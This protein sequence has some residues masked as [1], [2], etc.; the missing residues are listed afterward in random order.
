MTSKELRSKWL[1]FYEEKGHLNIGAV[2]LIG[3]G[4]TGVMFN[5]AGMQPLMP[6]LLGQPHPSGK[7]R[8][9]NVQGCVRTVDIESVG[10]AT[11]F[12]FFEM[13]GN[14]SLGDYFKKEKTAWTFELLTEVFGFDKDKICSTVFEGDEKVPRDEETADL[15]KSLGVRPENIFYLPKKDNWW[16][17]EGTVGTPCGPDNEWFYP[18][19][20]GKDS[21]DFLTSNRYVEIGNDVYMQYK[22]TET[23]YEELSGK[24]VDTGFG[25]DRLLLFLNG[26][27]DGYKTDLFAGAVSYLEKVSGRSYDSDEDARKAIRIIADHTRTA[28]MLIGDVNGILPSNTG[29]GYI[30]RRLLRRAIRYCRTLGVDTSA[31]LSVAKV[32]IEEVYGEAYPL[33]VE[34]EQYIL[35]AIENESQRFAATLAGGMRE[36]DKCIAGIQERNEALAAKDPGFRPETV[37]SGEQAF[38]LYDTFGFP[39]ELTEELAAEKGLTVDTE[40]YREC[41]KKQRETA[42]EAFRRNSIETDDSARVLESIDGGKNFTGY[43]GVSGESEIIAIV[44]GGELCG[45]VSEGED[46]IVVLES[47]PFYAESGGQVGDTGVISCGDSEFEVMDCK[48]SAQGHYMHIGRMTSGT[49]RNGDRVAACVDEGRR[50]AI[51][52]NHTSVH[53]LQAALRQVLGDHVHQAGSY[54]DEKQMRFDFTHFEAVKPEELA[55]VESIVNTK[56]LSG[57]PVSTEVLPLEEAQKQGAI[58]LFDEKYGDTVRVVSIGEFS[59]EFCGGTHASS[60]SDLGL[61]K[62]TGES[63]VASGVRRIEAVTGEG[64]LRLLDEQKGLLEEAAS[65]LKAGNI[66]EVPSRA[67]SVTA[68]IRA[69]EQELGKLRDRQSADA[70]K[71]IENSGQAIGDIVFFPAKIG[72]TDADTLRNMAAS[73]RDSRPGAVALIIASDGAKSTLCAACSKEAIAKGLKAGLLVKAA[74]QAMGG[75]G[76]GKDDLAMA[77]GKLPEKA[78]EAV[79]AVKAEIEKHI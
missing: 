18:R 39:L 35:N 42:R 55:E 60:T 51:R 31:M 19:E 70:V 62:I 53:L 45:D 64:V 1:K 61:Y 27:D 34:K 43:S 66:K 57:I 76:G 16:E 56:I 3:D 46:A 5:V 41:V 75:N 33:L 50:M 49:F 59:K 40:G 68:Q 17:L 7:K 67:A 69:L 54:V 12:T 8:L 24:N 30:L 72:N 20:D 21:S 79:T 9:C 73:L 11:H 10:D 78:D 13:M 44:R 77:G 52:R 4:T 28:V 36:F 48:K 74:A 37:I 23:G 6:Y 26:L 22:K 2:S 71:D 25:L 29:A 58:A 38:Q 63:S 32:F 14:W 65:V 47:T 15:L